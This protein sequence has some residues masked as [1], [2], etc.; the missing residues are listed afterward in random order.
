MILEI[1]E[2]RDNGLGMPADVL[3]RIFEPY[4]TIHEADRD[5]TAGLGWAQARAIIEDYG[6]SLVIT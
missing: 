5:D 3:D 6:G 4:Y 1:L 2:I